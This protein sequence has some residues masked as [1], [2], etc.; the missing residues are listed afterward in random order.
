MQFFT[1]ITNSTLILYKIRFCYRKPDFKVFKNRILEF[2]IKKFFQQIP[3]D[4]PFDA[5]LNSLQNGLFSFDFCS[6]EHIGDFDTISK[7]L[8]SL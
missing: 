1:L 2:L 6:L 3:K 8:L 7:S 5:E 4:I